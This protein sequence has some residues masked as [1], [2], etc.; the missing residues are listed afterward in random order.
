MDLSMA[1]ID[2]ISC[3]NYHTICITYIQRKYK[4]KLK[5]TYSLVKARAKID[6]RN[7]GNEWSLFQFKMLEV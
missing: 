7:Y 3:I 6:V 5:E 4:V 2:L 1:A